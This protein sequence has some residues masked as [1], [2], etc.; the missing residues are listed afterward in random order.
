MK[1]VSYIL[2]R[3]NE[4]STWRGIIGILTAIGVTISPEQ[5]DSIVAAGLAIMGAVG[6]FTKDDAG[7]STEA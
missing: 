7:S 5:I 1:I 6:V 4:A 2:E 3:L